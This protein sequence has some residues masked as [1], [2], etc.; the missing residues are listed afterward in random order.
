MGKKRRKLDAA[1]IAALI[2]RQLR[3][4][5]AQGCAGSINLKKRGIDDAGATAVA[6]ALIAARE[7]ARVPLALWRARAPL[8]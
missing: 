4:G 8:G 2:D 3:T 1:G 7:Q 6:G 5:A